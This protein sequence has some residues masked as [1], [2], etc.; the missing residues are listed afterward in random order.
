MPDANRVI[1]VGAGI[2]GLTCAYK[3]M[4][5]GLN[6]TLLESSERPGGLI[7]SI[8]QDGFLFERGPQSFQGTAALLDLIRELG[9]S[10][11]LLEADFAAPRYVLRAGRLQKIPISPQAMIGSSLLGAGSRWKIVSE[12]FRRTRPPGHEESVA[13]FV[14]RKFGHEILEYLVSPFVSGVY[15]GDPERLSL[16]A[17]FPTLEEWERQ[18]GSVLRGAMKSRPANGEKKKAPPL[19]SFRRG[20]STLTDALARSLGPSIR[21]GACVAKLSRGNT[22]GASFD[23]SIIEDGKSETISA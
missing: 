17:A 4:R 7:W 10:D 9:I 23:A 11:E 2:S 8:E 18:F 14:R 15:A 1:V 6:V 20:L 21:T 22:N 16:R 19:C 3:L 12:P 5:V 13:E